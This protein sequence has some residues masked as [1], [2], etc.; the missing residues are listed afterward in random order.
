MDD[1]FPD[2]V[3]RELAEAEEQRYESTMY[4]CLKNEDSFMKYKQRQLF[5]TGKVKSEIKP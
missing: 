4:A 5:P 2:R 3:D 1:T